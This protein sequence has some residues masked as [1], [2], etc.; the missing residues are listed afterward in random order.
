M[1]RSR[2]ERSWRSWRRGYSEPPSRRFDLGL[3]HGNR[4]VTQ[5]FVSLSHVAHIPFWCILILIVALSLPPLSAPNRLST[6]VV[7][8]RGRQSRLHLDSRHCQRP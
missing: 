4:N 2:E 6:S 1:E 8:G 3:A 5:F 7:V